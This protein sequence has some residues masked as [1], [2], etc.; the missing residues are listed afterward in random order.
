MRNLWNIASVRGT[1]KSGGWC[2]KPRPVEAY[3]TPQKD[4]FQSF[5]NGHHRT[6][7]YAIPLFRSLI[8]ACS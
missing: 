6:L 7:F 5:P 3:V 4:M 8:F 1:P 2:R